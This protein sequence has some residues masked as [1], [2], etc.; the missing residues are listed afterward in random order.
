M[1]LVFY[2]LVHSVNAVNLD[3]IR[4][5]YSDAVKDKDLC[6][7]LIKVLKR[8]QSNNVYL[9]YLGGLQ[10]IWANHTVNP[11]S[12]LRSFNEGR[13]NIEKAVN[14]EP[15][16]PEIRFVRLLVQKNAPAFLGYYQ[17]ISDDSIFIRNHRQR[18]QSDV[19]LKMVN[20]LINE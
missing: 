4:L 17:Q 3:Y 8:E 19:L 18:I 16:N 11:Y 20:R 12:K 5:H 14:N 10:T 7:S 6:Q 15:G 9:A 1:V 2:L 13:K